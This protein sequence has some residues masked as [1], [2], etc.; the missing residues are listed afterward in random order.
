[1][2]FAL[3]LPIES[4][5]HFIS[6]VWPP[7]AVLVSLMLVAPV[8]R[9][10]AIILPAAAAHLVA[11]SYQGTALWLMAIQFSHNCLLGAIVSL[12]M[13]RLFGGGPFLFETLRSTLAFLVVGAAIA[14]PVVAVLPAAIRGWPVPSP[15]FWWFWRRIAMSDALTTAIF[16]PAMVLICGGVLG[17]VSI[18]LPRRR[19]VLEIAALVALVMI[20]AWC[21]FYGPLAHLAQRVPAIFYLPLPLLLWA[22]VR[23]G[24]EGSSV[25]LSVVAVLCIYGVLTGT[26]PFG[27]ASAEERAISA[28]FVLLALCVP[29]LCL[30]AIARERSIAIPLARQRK[31]RLGVE[32]GEDLAGRLIEVQEVERARIA[33]E[34]HD[35][36]NQQLAALSMAIGKVKRGL[37]PS[38]AA[39]LE[40]ESVQRRAM[41]LTD[42]V[43][44]ICH[45]LHSGVLQHVGLS[46]AVRAYCNEAQQNHELTVSVSAEAD[47]DATPENVALCLYRILQEAIQNVVRHAEATEVEVQLVALGGGLEL[48]VIDNGKGFEVSNL[49]GNRGLGLISMDERMRMVQ[50]WLT[51]SSE[52]L[53]GTTLRAWAPAP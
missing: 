8:R 49:G 44:S 37:P 41:G 22:A 42:E 23:F 30:S 7:N 52:P 27:G 39:R 35:D 46:A 36:V 9:W 50:G 47:T 13:K 3:S 18:R 20:V 38:A 21:V 28:Q 29:M 1:V 19:V 26:G 6:I 4:S 14:A 12:A 10:G 53:K 33:R 24:P 34:L 15:Q 32:R 16:A 2:G 11:Q 5:H 43:R 17:F 40:L 25:S 48:T 51:I 45:G 31:V